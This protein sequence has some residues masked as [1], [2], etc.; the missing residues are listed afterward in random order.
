MVKNR[1]GLLAFAI[2]IV[3]SACTSTTSGSVAESAAPLGTPIQTGEEISKDAIVIAT[4]S[5]ES[6]VMPALTE[7]PVRVDLPDMGPA[8]A[9]ENEVW[10]NT[11]TPLSL[12]TE[13]GKVV[14]VEFWTFGCINCQR[15]IPWVKDW[16][17]EFAGPDFEVLSIHYPEFAYEEDYDNVVDATERF[18]IAYPVAIDNDGRTWSAYHQ[19]YW[20]TT[21][22]VDRNGRIRYRHIGE[23]N[24]STAAEAVA[25][26]NVLIAETAGEAALR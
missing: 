12:Q 3:L 25:A 23:F 14:L 20:P 21:Y 4:A 9:I 1:F 15:V 16:H 10:I 8:P 7:L 11:E 2:V 26:I 17:A 19:R 22:L 6:S 5:T 24:P 18:E 13:R